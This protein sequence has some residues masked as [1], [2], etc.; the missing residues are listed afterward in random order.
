MLTIR[1]EQMQAIAS[2]MFEAWIVSHLAEFFQEEISGLAPAEIHIR[3]RA[4]VEKA[5]QF[6]FLGDSE[7]CRY[8]DLSFILGPSF[9]RDPS[10]PWAAEILLDKRLNDSEMRMDL[11]YEAAQDYVERRERGERN[12]EVGE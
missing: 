3:I 7:L 2:G 6:G 5:R 1:H 10:L 9:D 4:A 12:N 8:I 11:L